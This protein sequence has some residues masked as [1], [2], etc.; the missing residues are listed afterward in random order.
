M[1]DKKEF[2]RMENKEVKNETLRDEHLDALI[3][4]AFRREEERTYQQL[5]EE[6]QQ[7]YTTEEAAQKDAIFA[8]AME[9]FAAQEKQRKKKERIQ[10][11]KRSVPQIINVAAC[12]ALILCIAAPIAVARVEFIRVRVMKLLIEIQE[13]HTDLSL[14]EDEEAAYYVPTDWKGEYYP[15]YLP[16]SCEVD[17][18]SILGTEIIWEDNSGEQTKFIESTEDNYISWDS[19]GAETSTLEIN[20]FDAYWIGKNGKNTIA[21]SDGNKYFILSTTYNKELCTQIAESVRKI[22]Q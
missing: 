20:G 19:E 8:R 4:L 9:K 12:L 13:D 21:W 3:R 2:N 16:E 7:E 15:A 6:N 14:V 22:E 11:M 10:R 17:W 1:P 18:I 5:M